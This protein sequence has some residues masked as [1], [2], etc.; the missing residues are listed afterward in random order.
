MT[1]MSLKMG[2]NSLYSNFEF[3]ATTLKCFYIYRIKWM[4][5]YGWNRNLFLEL[6]SAVLIIYI[7]I[8][9]ASNHHNYPH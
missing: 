4:D 1:F 5:G 2:P 3:V 7:I 8:I 9:V 6:R